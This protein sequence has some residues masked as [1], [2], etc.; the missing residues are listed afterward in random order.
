MTNSFTDTERQMGAALAEYN[1]D[2]R[3]FPLSSLSQAAVAIIR[4]RMREL[5][6]PRNPRTPK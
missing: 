6:V 3:D 4:Q 2:W 1:G 5:R